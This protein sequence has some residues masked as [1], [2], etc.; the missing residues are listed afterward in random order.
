MAFERRY[1]IPF[2][3]LHPQLRKR[4]GRI[5]TYREDRGRVPVPAVLAH[6]TDFFE[7]NEFYK[8]ELRDLGR[9]LRIWK[10][11]GR[12][13]IAASHFDIN[14]PVAVKSLIHP[15]FA[16]QHV[17]EEEL[18]KQFSHMFLKANG[19]LVLTNPHSAKLLT[20]DYGGMIRRLRVPLNVR[21]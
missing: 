6:A 13:R 7:Q 17:S 20:K 5:L 19:S 12:P 18:R 3:H 15:R 14:D 9:G 16:S 1:E 21:T 11:G 8:D 4:I 10:E 2:D